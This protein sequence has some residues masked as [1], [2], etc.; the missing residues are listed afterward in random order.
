MKIDP[1]AAI[2]FMYENAVKYAQAKADRFYLEKYR[3]SLKSILC[4]EALAKGYE[5]V[6]AQEREALSNTKYID[7][8][9]SIKH[10]M[11]IEET[12]RWQLIAAEARVEVWRTQS[13]NDRAM[14]RATV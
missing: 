4:K 5:A 1:N 9:M 10:A 6:N 13:A 2:D 12:L 8:L 14:D 11:E 3:E 7:H